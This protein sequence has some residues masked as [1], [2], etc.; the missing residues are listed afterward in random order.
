MGEEERSDRDITV[1]RGIVQRR[2]A[3]WVRL[4]EH[5]VPGQEEAVP[6]GFFLLIVQRLGIAG[7]VRVGFGAVL[8]EEFCNG[9][10]APLRRVRQRGPAERVPSL[11]V[12]LGAVREEEL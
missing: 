5:G 3:A 12:R 8:Q 10:T 2:K 11:D 4:L 6:H 9:V 7:A 1:R